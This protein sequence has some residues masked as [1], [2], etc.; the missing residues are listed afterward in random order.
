MAHLHIPPSAEHSMAARRRQTSY[1]VRKLMMNIAS[2]D[3][4]LHQVVADGPVLWRISFLK[5][6]QPAGLLV[7]EAVADLLYEF[8]CGQVRKRFREEIG[9]A[10]P[11]WT[12]QGIATRFLDHTPPKPKPPTVREIIDSLEIDSASSDDGRREVYGRDGSPQRVLERLKDEMRQAL[13]V[14]G[15]L[16]AHYTGG[17]GHEPAPESDDGE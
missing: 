11:G 16:P 6:T 12:P 4:L 5:E 9:Q 17:P 10:P 7:D 8:F 2:D 1:W 14:S 3:H 15:E 13:D